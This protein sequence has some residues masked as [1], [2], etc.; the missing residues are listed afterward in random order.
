VLNF[1]DVLMLSLRRHVSVIRDIP[2]TLGRASRA[3]SAAA[4]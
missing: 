4:P 2:G 3:M 1:I